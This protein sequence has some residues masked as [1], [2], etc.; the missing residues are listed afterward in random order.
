MPP[1]L[2]MATY[3]EV[4]VTVSDAVCLNS[5]HC[6]HHLPVMIGG[7]NAAGIMHPLP[8]VEASL[9]AVLAETYGVESKVKAALFN[10]ATAHYLHSEVLLA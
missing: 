4:A 7:R 6:R 5:R 8:Y 2:S 10:V 1:S 9:Y 3:P